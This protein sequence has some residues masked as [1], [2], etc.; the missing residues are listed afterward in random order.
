MHKKTTFR[1][2]LHSLK[3]LNRGR[4]DIKSAQNATFTPKF[5]FSHHGTPNYGVKCD[6]ILST[7]GVCHLRYYMEYVPSFRLKLCEV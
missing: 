3:R 5:H 4:N 2:P 6:Q 7:Q 1:D